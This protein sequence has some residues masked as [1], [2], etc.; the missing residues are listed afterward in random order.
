MNNTLIKINNLLNSM[1]LEF[2]GKKT[3]AGKHTARVT[4]VFKDSSGALWRI[5]QRINKDG[6][7]SRIIEQRVW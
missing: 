7:I 4:Q 2:I 3:Y 1:P 6:S 5:T